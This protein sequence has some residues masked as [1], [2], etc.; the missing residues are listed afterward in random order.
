[1]ISSGV[2]TAFASPREIIRCLKEATSRSLYVLRNAEDLGAALEIVTGL[3][4]ELRDVS[5]TQQ[6][7]VYNREWMEYL[8]LR[9]ALVTARAILTS[10]LASF[11]P[12]SFDTIFEVLDE[13]GP[14][15]AG[16]GLGWSV[17]GGSWFI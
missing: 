4:G 7:P 5:F 1:M 2:R 11:L 6:S 17:M 9:N 13:D 8:M 10:A 16:R 12:G 14:A 3:Q 15:S